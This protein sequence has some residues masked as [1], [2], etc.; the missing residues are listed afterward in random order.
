MENSNK[1]V[2]FKRVKIIN[3]YRDIIEILI[4][5]IWK[6]LGVNTDDNYL[7]TCSS[8]VRKKEHKSRHKVKW[9]KNQIDLVET[10]ISQFEILQD[11]SYHK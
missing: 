9:T 6:F 4:N 2:I 10:R 11:Y 3:K 5:T 8:I 1:R 7:N